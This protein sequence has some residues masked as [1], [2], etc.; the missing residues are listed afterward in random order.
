MV[1][2]EGG[3]PLESKKSIENSVTRDIKGKTKVFE[4]MWLV[5][6]SG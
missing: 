4:T 1:A 3:E 6:K 5:G 2:V